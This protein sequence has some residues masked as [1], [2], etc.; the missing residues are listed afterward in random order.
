MDSTKT[1]L[2]L[3]LSAFV[4]GK[5]FICLTLA[6]NAASEI[7]YTTSKL[8]IHTSMGD[9]S[10]LVVKQGKPRLIKLLDSFGDA[11]AIKSALPDITIVGRIYLDNQPQSGD[12]VDTANWWWNTTQQTILNSPGVDFWEGYNEPDVSSTTQVAWLAS[13]DAARVQILNAHGLKAS[14][15][16]FGTGTPDVSNAGL[17]EAFYPAIDAA[18]KYGG[19]LG[20]HEYSSPYMNGSF[21]GSVQTGQGWLTGRYRKLYDQYL[22]PTNRSIPLVISENGIDGGT[23]S[24]TGCN[25]AGGWQNFCSYWQ[26]QGVSDCNAAYVN[27]LAWYDQVMQQDDYVI[28]STIFCLEISGWS[29]F[30]IGPAVPDLVAYMQQS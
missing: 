11:P 14:I 9:N 3:V 25:I 24:I 21:S 29:D 22:L 17:I 20:L 13:F 7:D 16:N 19:I 5:L 1:K 15:G 23:C 28:G 26:S 12:P 2:G 10:W 4:V 27:Q 6:A 18:V 30:D 8:S